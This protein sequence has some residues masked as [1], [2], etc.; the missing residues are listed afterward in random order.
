M[1]SFSQF[2]SGLLHK[3]HPD[4]RILVT[5][6][7][8]LAPF[9]IILY[10]DF[11]AYKRLSPGGLPHNFKGWISTNILAFRYQNPPLELSYYQELIDEGDDDRSWLGE[12]EWGTRRRDGVRPTV[13]RHPVPNRQLDQIPADEVAKVRAFRNSRVCTSPLLLCPLLFHPRLFLFRLLTAN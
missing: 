10:R 8:I 13:G 3:C 6:S 5:G 7:I 11:R 2:T 12:K 4:G 1:S 9:L